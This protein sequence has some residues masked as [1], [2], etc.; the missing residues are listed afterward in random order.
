[1]VL[2]FDQQA[3]YSAERRT[4]RPL[5]RFAFTDGRAT[6]MAVFSLIYPCLTLAEKVDPLKISLDLIKGG[7]TPGVENMTEAIITQLHGLLDPILKGHSQGRP[8]DERWYW[9]S[10]ALL[11]NKYYPEAIAEWLATDEETISWKLMVRSAEEEDSNFGEHVNIFA[12]CLKKKD[13]LG[14]PP[15][16]LFAVLAKVTLASPATTT[17][18]SF[19]PFQPRNLLWSDRE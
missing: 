13:D 19:K 16:D 5:L 17:L 10:M 9:A 8:N 2:A 4:R 6:G 14:Q 1:M 3:D 11:D 15:E 7:K 12:D 18:R